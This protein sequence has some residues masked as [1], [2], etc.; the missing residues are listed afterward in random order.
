MTIAIYTVGGSIGPIMASLDLYRPGRVY[1]IASA[2]SA[3]QLDDVRGGCS[4]PF[5]S[6]TLVLE[7]EQDLGRC[8]QALRGLCA[9]HPEWDGEAKAGRL[10]VDFTGGT[11]AMVAA[12]AMVFSRMHAVFCYVGGDRRAKSGL[13]IVEAG[14]ERFYR[15]NNPMPC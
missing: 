1:F 4:F 5:D 12:A 2:M 3:R 13:G 15:Q 7:D 8:V 6:E 14:S 11:K 9:E 10:M